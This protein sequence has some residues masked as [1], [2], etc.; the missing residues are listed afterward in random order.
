MRELAQSLLVDAA[1][2]GEST[3]LVVVPDGNLHYLPFSAL[4]AGGGTA[5]TPLIESVD[6]EYAPALTLTSSTRLPAMDTVA[7]VV[8]EDLGQP[9]TGEPAAA[10]RSAGDA[11]RSQAWNSEL[12]ALPWAATEAREIRDIFGT[13]NTLI[14]EGPLANFDRF[15]SSAALGYDIIHFA[16]HGYISDS[17]PDVAG[18]V[19]HGSGGEEQVFVHWSEFSSLDLSSKL[20]V[21]NGCD[22]ALG[23]ELGGEGMLGL[24]RAFI[25][26]GVPQ[27]LTTLWKVADVPASRIMSTFYAELKNGRSVAKAIRRAQL[28]LPASNPRYRH[29]FFWAGYVVHT[30]G[31]DKT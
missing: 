5:Y 3:R 8:T 7:V 15:R 23:R 12:V 14:L 31:L 9:A 24:N 29:P 6:V 21:L 11:N 20:V 10:L 25:S 28:A 22:T 26:A 27:T 2:T 4:D 17:N 30:A 13:D 16:T 1:L 18:L 19:L